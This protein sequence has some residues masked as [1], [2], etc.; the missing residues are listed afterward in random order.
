MTKDLIFLLENCYYVLEQKKDYIAIPKFKIYDDESV[1]LYL[2]NK[3]NDLINNNFEKAIRSKQNSKSVFEYS[4]NISKM[5]FKNSEVNKKILFL[6][7]SKNEE[8]HELVLPFLFESINN[9]FVNNVSLQNSINKVLNNSNNE[10]KLMILSNLNNKLKFII[11]KFNDI[12]KLVEIFQ[13]QTNNKKQNISEIKNLVENLFYDLQNDSTE[14]LNENLDL[15]NNVLSRFLIYFKKETNGQVLSDKL[16][17]NFHKQRLNYFKL[18]NKNDKN[19]V[20]NKYQIRDLN[21]LNEELKKE[22][23][24]KLNLTHNRLN[25]ISSWYEKALWNYHK[26]MSLYSKKSFQ[27]QYLLKLKVITKYVLKIL[28]RNKRVIE[29]LNESNLIAIKKDLDIQIRLFLVNNLTF[30]NEKD[31]INERKLNIIVEN[32]FEFNIQSYIK[33]SDNNYDRY[34]NLIKENKQRINEL[35][36]DEKIK[37]FQKKYEKEIKEVQN[38]INFIEMEHY[39]RQK[40]IK[41]DFFVLLK[42]SKFSIKKL[43]NSLNVVKNIKYFVSKT[44]QNLKRKNK[45]SYRELEDNQVI[46]FLEK[47]R[48]LIESLSKFLIFDKLLIDICLQNSL[49][50]R[51]QISKILQ[52]VQLVKII[53]DISLPVKSL[54]SEISEL[55]YVNA[56]KI[57]FLSSIVENPKVIFLTDNIYNNND[58]GKSEFLKNIKNY[59][60]AQKIAFVFITDNFNLI[61][62]TSFDYLY[63]MSNH[64]VIETGTLND[65]IN[66]PINPYLKHLFKNLDNSNS[67]FLVENNNDDKNNYLFNEIYDISETHKVFAEPNQIKKWVNNAVE[68]EE[69]TSIFNLENSQE[70]TIE[71][72]INDLIPFNEN[73]EVFITKLNKKQM[74]RILKTKKVQNN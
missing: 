6:N 8:N 36:K 55:S 71:N 5:K 17:K 63:V 68:I 50:S 65:L 46:E 53:N 56:Q 74:N 26:L 43:Q 66:D 59:C 21:N 73:K 16:V 33:N 70:G 32:E 31:K 54:L 57:N 72:R 23:K 48:N 12:Y 61:N 51:K 7:L 69:K 39:W 20:L 41:N 28:K 15:F 35:K 2:T 19:T 11:N 58:A 9:N 24:S 4:H 13:K 18:L 47:I 60:V 3:S 44:V 14:F 37:F 52:M 45:F 1:A 62:Q 29:L 38:Q 25:Y 67:S 42:D 40:R 10:I 64:K 22:F 49:P 30:I 34:F 27:F